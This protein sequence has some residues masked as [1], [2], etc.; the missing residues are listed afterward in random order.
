[1]ANYPLITVARAQAAEQLTSVASTRLTSLIASAS[2]AIERHC[3]RRFVSQSFTETH[4]GDGASELILEHFPLISLTSVTIIE[5]DGTEVAI[6]ATEFRTKAGVGL[7]RF[8]PDS[9]AAYRWF[10]EGFQNVRIVQTAGFASVPEDVQEA[11][12]LLVAALYA[13]ER[14]DAGVSSEKLGD[15]SVTLRDLAAGTMPENVKSL[16]SS[17]RDLRAGRPS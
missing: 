10:P 12:V 13:G 11:C 16:L 7:I 5:D 8:K 15:Y 6:A 1:M 17:Y 3:N 2:A 4:D 9:T 14:K